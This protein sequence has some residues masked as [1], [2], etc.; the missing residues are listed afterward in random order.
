MTK[1][2]CNTCEFNFGDICAGHAKRLD[3]N[4]D[5][6]GSS[7]DEMRTMF[8]CGCGDWGISLDAFIVE[9]KHKEAKKMMIIRQR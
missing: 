5:I 9:E 7:L 6:Y 3:N 8:P 1:K 2:D 4:E